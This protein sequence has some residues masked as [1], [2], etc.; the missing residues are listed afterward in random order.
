MNTNSN[1]YTVVYTTVI[2]VIVAAV[3]AFVSGKLGPAQN[4]NAKAETLRQMMSAA[5]IRPTD[6]LY[7][8]KNAGILQLYADNIQEAYTIG[9]DGE[10][11]ERA[12]LVWTPI[13]ME[14]IKTIF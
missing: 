4:A 13:G 10:K 3:L 14:F 8:T 6:E 5:Q 9:L 7:A 2:V 1:V 11:K 12:Y